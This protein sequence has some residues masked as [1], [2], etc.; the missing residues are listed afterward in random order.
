MDIK[1][2]NVDSVKYRNL[3]INSVKYNGEEVWRLGTT[4]NGAPPLV[5]SDSTGA[6]IRKYIVYGNSVQET[7]S[8]KNILPYPYAETTKRENGL[9]FTDN[10]DG[11][12]TVNG[13]A[14][15]DTTFNLCTDLV[16]TAGTYTFSGC[17]SGGSNTTYFI[18][19]FTGT[20]IGSGF[21]VVLDSDT[22][23]SLSITIKS[24]TTIAKVFK[25]Q[26]EVGSEKT[27][28]EQYG[29]MPSPNFPSEIQSVGDLVTDTS[30]EYY[31]KYDV[32][33]TVRG[34]NLLNTYGFSAESMLKPSSPRVL[35]NNHGTT[36]STI[37]PSDSITIT[38]VYRS[39]YS[40]ESYLNGYFCVGLNEEIKIGLS[41]RI[42]FDIDIISNP[43]NAK[44]ITILINGS[45][46][47]NLNL[48]E[49]RISNSFIYSKNSVYPTRRFIEFRCMGMSFTISNIM[50]TNIENKDI[51]YEPYTSSTQ[52]IYLDE[53]LR[54]IGDY[55]DY[56]DFRNKKVVRNIYKRVFVGTENWINTNV[57]R[58][59]LMIN[60]ISELSSNRVWCLC[61]RL[62]GKTWNTIWSNQNLQDGS[63]VVGIARKSNSLQVTP[64]QTMP[65]LDEWKA[66]LATWNE[67]GNPFTVWYVDLPREEPIDNL[68]VIGTNEGT[69]TIET[70]TTIQP[71]N[72]SVTYIKTK[73]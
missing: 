44:Y 46:Q 50:I 6:N 73:G 5:L 72:M 21:T 36:I 68:P 26:I 64:N 4:V 12:I 51:E 71:S 60:K 14:S 55:R 3:N 39:N 22:T 19:G 10:G 27:S 20:D 17:P 49:G 13:T 45:S 8:G 58:F 32:P 7:R 29:A 34:K 59:Y 43:G 31:G 23:G 65:T 70:D 66:Q 57:G 11:T 35:K 40:L 63:Y 37:N 53:P 38:Q 52:H 56:I 48:Q 30:S 62:I 9:T 67:E 25:P 18:S 2:N 24:G 69:N 61:N 33:V 54:G 15:A 42:S 16:L 28:Y 47:Y 1:L 41:Y